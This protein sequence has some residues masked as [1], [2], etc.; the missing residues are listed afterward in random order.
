MAIGDRGEYFTLFPN[1]AFGKSFLIFRAQ[2]RVYIWVRALFF[3]EKLGVL[4]SSDM[5]F[6]KLFP[7]ISNLIVLGDISLP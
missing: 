4:Q 3:R 7:S 5:I 2:G 1:I 6:W